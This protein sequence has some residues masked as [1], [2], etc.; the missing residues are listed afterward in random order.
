MV[1]I[2]L[3]S[4]SLYLWHWP[5]IA[6]MRLIWGGE[7]SLLIYLLLFA[8]MFPIAW[9]SWRFIE[10]PFRRNTVFTRYRLFATA[11]IT[12]FAFLGM[13]ILV[14]KHDGFPSRFSSAALVIADGANDGN[15]IGKACEAKPVADIMAGRICTVGRSEAPLTFALIG[16]SFA[17]AL[18]PGVEAA[19]DKAGQRG[20]V[21]TRGGCYALIGVHTVNN[22]GCEDSLDAAIARI[23]AT[24][25][26]QTVILISRWTVAAEGTRFGALTYKKLFITDAQSKE[27]SY[28]ENKAV[29]VRSL[30]R[31]AHALGAYRVF[32]VASIPEQLTNVPQAA[33]LRIQ[34]GLYDVGTPREIVER[35]QSSAKQILL[36]AAV[37]YGF[38]I[39]DA[40]LPLCDEQ[41]CRS[42]EDGKSLYADENHLSRF[43]ALKESGVLAAAF[44]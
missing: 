3:I 24:P 36:A 9:L 15:P 14:R 43:G 12:A 25:T 11:G 33:A 10:R 27:P 7:Q 18:T 13:A 29:F 34:F 20:Y 21:L 41:T 40:M 1:W 37:R 44:R 19:A 32:V 39:L 28:A 2:G 6:F 31:N 4:Y 5:L 22:P 35:R 8:S 30:E 26:I 23:K 16:D 38:N 17:N 42:I